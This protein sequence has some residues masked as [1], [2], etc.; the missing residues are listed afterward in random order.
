MSSSVT[1]HLSH[2][3]KMTSETMTEEATLGQRVIGQRYT[4]ENMSLDEIGSM[5]DAWSESKNGDAGAW[6]NWLE[7]NK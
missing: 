7:A 4:F 2:G 5:L 1:Y 3:R 6:K